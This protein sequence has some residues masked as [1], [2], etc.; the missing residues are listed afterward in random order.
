[1]VRTALYAALIILLIGMHPTWALEKTPE[2]NAIQI[3]AHPFDLAQVRLLKG[4]FKDAMQR[5][6]KY[7][8]DLDP[9]RL[10][11]TF[12]LNAG[13]PSS[14]E[15][16][17]GWEKPDCEL[18]G[19]SMGH[20]LSA[21]AMMYSSTG[22]ERLK[23]KAD[24]IVAELAKCQSALGDSG[25]L[26]AFP[27]TWFDRVE[28]F[29]TV[30]APYYTLHKIYAGLL[31]MYVHCG[32]KQAL[33]IAEKMAAWNKKRLDK[34]DEAHMQRMLDTTEQGGM[35][36]VLANLFAVTGNRDY[37]A[38]SRRFNQ[39]RYV[40][41]L[42]R[43][44]DRL[45]GEHANSFVPNVIGTARQYELIGDAQDR[46]I[47]EYFWTQV[48]NHRSY[49]TGGTSNNE[50]WNSD[51]DHLSHE[52]GDCTQETCCTYNM[53]KLTRH[54]FT[55][56]PDV[57][58][59]DYYERALYN[60]ILST[61]NPKTG[62]MMYFVP[63][64]TGRWKMY[65][66]PNESFWCCTGTGMENHT[67]Y[68]DSI[69]FHN[70]DT[71]YVNLFIASELNW[72]QKN[73]RIRQET[74]FP[75]KQFTSLV[76]KTRNPARIDMRIRIPGWLAGPVAL[77]L[78][79]KTLSTK[80]EPGTYLKLDRTWKN[81]DRLQIPLPMSLHTHPMPDDPTLVAF[82]YGPFV[83]AGK[84]GGE[85]LTEENTHTTE[86][87]YKFTKDVASTP[88]LIVQSDNPDNLIAPVRGSKLTFQTKGQARKINLVPYHTLFNQRYVV[89][90]RVLKE[91]SDAHKKYLAAEERRKA[92]LAQTIDS[93]DIGNDAS[94]REHAF[95][96]PDT[97]AGSHMGRTWRHA[98][99]GGWL[100]YKLK[101][102]PDQPAILR[103]TFWG[104]DVGRTF[105]V[106]VDGKKIATV[107]LNNNAPD[108]FFDV[109]YNI[110]PE[111]TQDKQ[112]V[113]VKFQAHQGNTAGGLFGCAILKAE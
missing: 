27:E 79:G 72:T 107:T 7:L 6:R 62:M 36:E 68:G 51:P 109:D 21:C 34:L 91:G 60:S 98:A 24:A 33:E 106:M 85:G 19:H 10:L 73:I 95:Q 74:D 29:K 84:L 46:N 8:H 111:L 77:K 110:P 43:K 89:Y 22:D 54:L 13:L 49:C 63:L 42:A 18:R 26:S 4:P 83:L 32:N 31:D 1:M 104:S 25:Y 55:W 102:L 67:K 37:L 23:A 81:G 52:L 57:R 75:G 50:H 99:N 47:A 78:N 66:L 96:G 108:K 103:C 59:S 69:Y 70:A 3:Q 105:D 41:P 39:N 5:D 40:E 65:N 92:L 101:V 100:S 20:Y 58:Y 2:S 15:P 53:L 30:W 28:A 90:W 56:N 38:M 11:H 35:N 93:V 44:E 86:N 45:K 17:G 112:N 94:E 82:M 88:P 113:T 48:V 80:V 87:W 12:R 61:Q 71:L 97:Q 16:L 14:A 9:D 76:V 64:A